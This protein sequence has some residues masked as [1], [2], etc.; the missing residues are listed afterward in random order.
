MDPQD[1]SLRELSALQ[2]ARRQKMADKRAAVLARKARTHKLI[3]IGG[4]LASL[5]PSLMELDDDG[6][7]QTVTGLFF[8]L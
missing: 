3:V 5:I 6:I 2:E 8:Q 4:T 1:M 7:R